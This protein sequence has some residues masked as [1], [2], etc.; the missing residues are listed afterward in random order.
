MAKQHLM[1]PE[2]DQFC[3]NLL[4]VYKIEIWK[5]CGPCW[6]HESILDDR[7]GLPTSGYTF[8]CASH[9]EKINACVCTVTLATH[10][11]T[12]FYHM[13][14]LTKA[15]SIGR[16]RWNLTSSDLGPQFDFR[17]P[18]GIQIT[19]ILTPILVKKQAPATNSKKL[20]CKRVSL[21]PFGRDIFAPCRT[22]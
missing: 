17:R 13:H 12:P 21:F 7:F 16:S 15:C 18:V 4:K 22:Q 11:S 2:A 6:Q 14:T 3:N 5:G 8:L 19:K 1:T 10:S 20:T 9:S